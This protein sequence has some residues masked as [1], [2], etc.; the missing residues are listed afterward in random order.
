MS[1][2]PKYHIPNLAIRLQKYAEERKL[3]FAKY[4]PFHMRIMD[5]GFTTLDIWTTGRYYIVTTDYLE[6]IGPGEDERTGE[7][8]QIKMSHI[9]DW[10]D[11]LFFPE[12]E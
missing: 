12:A 4:S 6:M 5:G 9:E 8:G 11:Q 10:L 7:K 2:K 3:D 1:R